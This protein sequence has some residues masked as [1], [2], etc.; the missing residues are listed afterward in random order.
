MG[1][2]LGE[3]FTKEP[4]AFEDFK[5]RVI[6]IDGYNVLHQ[7]LAIIRQRDGTPLKDAQ[8][9]ITS[10]L[11]GLFYRTAN[12][13]EARIRPVFVFDGVPHPLKA[14]TIQQRKERKEQAEKA[15]K[16]ALERGDLETAKSKASQTSRVTEEI[17]QQ[18]KDLLEAL[19]IPYIQA[20]SEGEA[21]ASYLVSKGDAY[22]VGSQ[23]F[24]CLLFGS[25]ILVRNLT[26]SE[27]RKLP[28]KNAY[29]TVHPEAI[30]LQPGLKA[31]EVTREQLVDIAILIGT[32]FNGGIKGFG[33]KKSLQLIKKTGCLEK[34][35]ETIPELGQNL[36]QQE[37]ETIRRIFLKPDVTDEYT[38]QWSTPDP[39]RV[40]HIMCDEHQFSRERVEP[41][42]EKFSF[43]T[44]LG[45]QRNLFDF[46]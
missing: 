25:P 7:F 11:S 15:W 8:G 36:P 33:P 44:H 45:K 1:V 35:L 16:E 46:S 18:S 28:G 23:D 13:V 34:A 20:P 39:S 6:A 21:Q 29:T 2:D 10:H 42:L 43:L 17:L 27:R 40:L 5:N 3:L 22:A 24:D 38:V 12:M 41:I 4:C 31:L 30:R 19:G 14:R 37:I 26:S 9:R 32:D